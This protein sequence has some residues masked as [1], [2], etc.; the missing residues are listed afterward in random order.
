MSGAQEKLLAA[1]EVLGSDLNYL[2]ELFSRVCDLHRRYRDTSL[3]DL[4]AALADDGCQPDG[5]PYL[6]APG[7]LSGAETWPCAQPG[8][9]GGDRARHPDRPRITARI[10]TRACSTFWER[11]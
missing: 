3:R 4:R 7:G 10:S 9:R 5:L 6:S 2:T 1:N 11:F 8:R